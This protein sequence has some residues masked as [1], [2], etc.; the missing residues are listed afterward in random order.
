[1]K[2]YFKIIFMEFNP[3]FVFQPAGLF[4]KDDNPIFVP[5][6]NIMEIL[7]SVMRSFP[8]PKLSN[9]DVIG[10]DTQFRILKN[11][12]DR[13][14]QPIKADYDLMLDILAQTGYK[15]FE[16]PIGFETYQLNLIEYL[17]ALRD[18]DEEKYNK[19]LEYE[20]KFQQSEDQVKLIR[21]E[22][23]KLVAE[24]NN[25]V[26]PELVEEVKEAI[27]ELPIKEDE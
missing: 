17:E 19:C 27:S 8:N 18:N 16:S 12:L 23:D 15:L 9:E 4:M 21:D 11:N 26:T 1:M 25:P 24:K 14:N 10:R 2:Y 6:V 5:V 3:N 20:K 7:Q 22:F 13:G